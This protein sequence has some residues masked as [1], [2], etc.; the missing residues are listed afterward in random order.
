MS[1]LFSKIATNRARRNLKI[2]IR[3]AASAGP[4]PAW[5][6]FAPSVGTVK[7][8]ESCTGTSI[9][10]YL[11]RP[12]SRTNAKK[13]RGR[14]PF[15]SPGS[16]C[17]LQFC[18]VISLYFGSWYRNFCVTPNVDECTGSGAGHLLSLLWFINS[19]SIPQIEQRLL[20]LKRIRFLYSYSSRLNSENLNKAIVL[21][22]LTLPVRLL[23]IKQ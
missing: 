17:K 12:E 2:A 11:L 4:T 19:N 10:T 5:S 8:Q 13:P 1:N 18:M 15:C 22:F 6:V 7:A 9:Q 14:A 16:Y 3:A 20:N 21:A 23:I